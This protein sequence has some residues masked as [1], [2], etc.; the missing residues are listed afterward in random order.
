MPLSVYIER[1][2]ARYSGVFVELEPFLIS[3]Q[4]VSIS[5]VVILVRYSLYILWKKGPNDAWLFIFLLIGT[6][7]ALTLSDLI[8]GGYRPSAATQEAI[9]AKQ[10]HHLEQVFPGLLWRLDE[11]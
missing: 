11:N 9:A 8:L 2:I 10:S 6:T 4:L 3:V 7:V 5:L 1:M